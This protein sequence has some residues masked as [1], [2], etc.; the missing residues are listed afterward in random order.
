MAMS[1]TELPSVQLPEGEHLI[2][3]AGTLVYY[4]DDSGD[5]RFGNRDHPFLAFGGVACT[6]EFH[7]K[8]ADGWKR[9]KTSTFPQVRGPLH[10]TRH[11]KGRAVR[12]WRAVSAAMTSQYLGRFC[13]VLTDTTSVSLEQVTLVALRTLAN[14]FA[15]IAQGMLARGLW[16][17]PSR[18]FVIFEHSARLA[19]HIESAFAGISVTA[20]PHSTPVEGCFMPKAVANPFLEMADCIA[21]AATKNVKYQRAHASPIVCTPTFQS[22]FRDVGPPLASYMEVTAVGSPLA[23][24][25]GRA[26]RKPIKELAAAR[27][28]L[29][30]LNPPCNVMAGLVPAIHVFGAT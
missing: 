4:V 28:V 23:R 2:I 29:L 22:L 21:N 10:A 8:L 9:M 25:M 15:D 20:G 19:Q 16:R 18:I 7:I 3:P 12:Q 30:L 24:G 11:L 14:R 1:A 27:W 13:A 6:S 17:P 5:E 26:K